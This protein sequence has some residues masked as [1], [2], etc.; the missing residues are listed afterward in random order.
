MPKKGGIKRKVRSKKFPP[1]ADQPRVEEGSLSVPP[2]PDYKNKAS[3]AR[4]IKIDT[5]EAERKKRLIMR[6]GVSSVMAVFFVIWIFNLKYEFKTS[7]GKSVANKFDLSQARV[8][9]DKTMKQ[10]KRGLAEV[11]KIQADSGQ[12]SSSSEPKLTQEQIEALKG[13]LLN[14]AATGT[15]S[16]TVKN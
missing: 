1:K 2:E 9:L 7:A 5:Q 14:E 10:L 3:R 12:G 15:A 8:E 16:S 13:K 6:L 11:K 4:G